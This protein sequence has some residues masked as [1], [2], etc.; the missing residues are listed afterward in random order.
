M[1]WLHAK[2]TAGFYPSNSLWIVPGHFGARGTHWGT[3]PSWSASQYTYFPGPRQERGQRLHLKSTTSE[4]AGSGQNPSLAEEPG[5]RLTWP[6][7]HPQCNP[8]HT[9]R[10]RCCSE[11]GLAQLQMTR[12][13]SVTQARLVGDR[14]QDLRKEA[15]PLDSHTLQRYTSR[16]EGTTP[17]L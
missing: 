10:G 3:W 14:E 12:D 1:A 8:E 4:T 6:P 16:P 2:E 5:L 15:G 13:S 7:E 11:T 17:L 9:L